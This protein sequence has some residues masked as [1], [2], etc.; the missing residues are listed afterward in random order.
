M[1]LLKTTREKT[2]KDFGHQFVKHDSL[3]GHWGSDSM[4]RD[5]FG[6]I[7]DPNEI[8][9]KLVAEI[10][11]G[12]GRILRMILNYKPKYVFAVEPSK[13]IEIAKENLKNFSNI[14]YLNETG[15]KFDLSNNE[16][17]ADYIFSLGVIHHIKNPGDVL[18]N[19]HRSLKNDGKFIIWVYGR[20]DN[21]LYVF[22]YKFLTMGANFFV[23]IS[24]GS[25]GSEHSGRASIASIRRR[26]PCST[27]RSA[28]P[29]R[30]G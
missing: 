22:L 5:F 3:G 13:S 7:F 15:D 4:F 23:K 1:A 12:S 6:D 8:K 2:I 29:V 20:E 9:G 26:A 14:T 16:G 10:G 18:L 28:R 25:Y 30:P 24:R 27:T 11:S 17:G 19:I 21:G